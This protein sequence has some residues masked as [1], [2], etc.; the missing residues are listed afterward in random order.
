M[1]LNEGYRYRHVLGPSAAGHTALSYLSGAFSHSTAAEWRSRL[2]AGEVYLSGKPAR[3]LD[4]LRPGEVLVWERPPWR[5]EDTPQHYGLIYQDDD[6][7]VVDKPSGL[8]TL[9]GGGFYRNT[10]LNF[11]R[12]DFPLARPLHRLGRGTSGLVVFAMNTRTAS[13][14]HRRWPQVQKQ[15]RALAAG[16]AAADGY[17]IRAPIGLVPHGR[18]GKVHAATPTGKPAR[19]VART[20]RR[21]SDAT[22]FEVDLHSGRPHQIRI[23]L[24]SI[25]HPLQGDPLYAAGG[26]PKL[27]HPGL[28]GDIGYHL[29]A[30]RLSFEHPELRQRLELTAPVPETL[31]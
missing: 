12:A 26:L 20:Y 19:S 2:E 24:A 17:D 28:P 3:E 13:A 23:H 6:L 16:E 14:L 9:P 30:A 11:V 31:R 25:G 8:P 27:D 10:L 15:Y 22:V 4:A 21:L 5:E 1:P 7:I 29:H 18:L